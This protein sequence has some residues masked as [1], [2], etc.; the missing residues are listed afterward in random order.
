M[1]SARYSGATRASKNVS[2]NGNVPGRPIISTGQA[3]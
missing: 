3:Q 1:K 2:C